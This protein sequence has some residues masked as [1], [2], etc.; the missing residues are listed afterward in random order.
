MSGKG[1]VNNQGGWAKRNCSHKLLSLN[2]GQKKIRIQIIRSSRKSTSL[3][4]MRTG[5]VVVR[6]PY[7]LADQEV[8]AFL[9]THKMW[10]SKKL[11]EQMARQPYPFPVFENITKSE[12][13]RIKKIISGKVKYFA[14]IMGVAYGKI[15]VRN[16]K[17]RWGSCSSK[18]NLNFNYRLAYLPDELLDYVV[19]HE[20][21]HR[22]HMNHSK[23]FWQTV[24][25]FYPDYQLCKEKLRKI[26]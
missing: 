2:I 21:A 8:K 17:T 5:E 12:M 20:L 26:F 4:I 11:K 18:G 7:C 13:E 9:E 25:I 19:V 22:I 24:A 1:S 16:Q 6:A 23:E 15:T 10:L 3:E 14:G